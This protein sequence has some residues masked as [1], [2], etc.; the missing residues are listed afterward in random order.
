M[1]NNFRNTLNLLFKKNLFQSQSMYFPYVQNFKVFNINFDFWIVDETARQWYN[2]E[3]RE[4]IAEIKGL[5]QLASPGDK[6]LEIG[7]HH[8][9][10]A[11]LLSKLIEE[12]GHIV[13][14]EALPSNAQIAHSQVSLNNL[15]NCSIK[16]F[17]ASSKTGINTI[18]DISNASVIPVQLQNARISQNIKSVSVASIR[19]DDLLN[20]YGYEKFDLIKIDVEGFEAEVLRG[21]TNI[22]AKYPKIALELHVPL[23]EKYQTSVEEIFKLINID[24]YEGVMI[25]RSSKTESQPFIKDMIPNDI[26]NL[27]LSPKN[28]NH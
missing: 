9:F 22:L 20:E 12:Q 13:S 16:N 4:S 5:I 2:P 21:C 25:S 7:C 19:G 27:I 26:V 17:V 11:V 8:G 6:I 15:S 3:D 1:L 10:H 23:L 14:I 28:L 18:S 24:L